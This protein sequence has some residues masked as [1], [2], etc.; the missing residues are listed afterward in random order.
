MKQLKREEIIY[1]RFD[2]EKQAEEFAK[3]Q[4]CLNDL[5]WYVACTINQPYNQKKYHICSMG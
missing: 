3:S 4:K 2:T 1:E 5:N